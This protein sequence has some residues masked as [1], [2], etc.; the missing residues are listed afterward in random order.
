MAR[1]T[2]IMA[3]IALLA[4][5][6]GYAMFRA[7]E[8]VVVPVAASLP[9]VNGSDWHTD[10][11]VLNPDTTV[12]AA[13]KVVFLPSGNQDD[14]VWFND[15]AH[16]LGYD[17]TFGHVL[18][19]GSATSPAFIPPGQSLILDDVLSNWGDQASG[20]KGALIVYAYQVDA[21]TGALISPVTPTRVVVASRTFTRSTASDGSTQTYGQEVPGIPWPVVFDAATASAPGLDHVT[22]TGIREDA[23]YRTAV[24]LV[25]LSATPV[26][27][28][29]TL[30][31][32]DG[33]QLAAATQTL[34]PYA[35]VQFNSAVRTLF[36]LSPD[37]Q[38]SVVGAT[39]KI[40]LHPGSIQVGP[41]FVAYCSRVDNTTNGP[42]Y[43]EA[44]YDS[45]LPWNC[46]YNATGCPAAQAAT[47]PS[48]LAMFRAATL[49]VVPV[50][51]STAGVN[52]SNWQSDIEIRNV[53]TVPVDVMIV[54]LPTGGANNLAWYQDITNALLPWTNQGSSHVNTSL[55]NIQPGQVVTLENI[56][57]NGGT[58]STSNG[59]GTGDEGALLIWGIQAGSFTSTTPTG[60][61][62]KDIVVTSRT[63]T[64]P[65][66]GT[67]GTYGQEIP[68]LPWYD[69]LDPEKDSHGFN[70]V[71]F[72]GIREDAS[73]RTAVGLV[74]VSDGLT[75]LYPSLNLTNM[76]DANGNLIMDTTVTPA[77]PLGKTAGLLINSLSHSQYN[78]ATQTMFGLA[79]ATYPAIIGATLTATVQSWESTAAQPTPAMVVYCSRVDNHTNDPVYLEQTWGVGLPWAC[80]FDG[81]SCTS[82]TSVGAQRASL[83]PVRPL[84]PPRGKPASPASAARE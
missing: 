28:D 5:N 4:A 62:P 11:E 44:I 21:T 42:D 8:R 81:Q 46:I 31:G 52:N 6:G 14:T 34:Q 58:N 79:S 77:V 76:K 54:F 27:V 33:G 61:T 80:A 47:A 72:T 75:Y 67:T 68:G 23:S 32:A 57:V 1:R 60:G 59:W 50:V 45:E 12:G 38:P 55:A 7:A 19:G 48:T 51:A 22:F 74:N 43:L 18:P 3:A 40:A 64:A 73:Y 39:L 29:L 2:G 70:K 9:G 65:P 16:Q 30:D 17:T 36:G 24:G 53:D 78:D 82:T 69:Y 15:P 10:L 84:D 37:A 71:T 35:H 13:L 66:T 41:A 20:L 63:Y 25:G 26:T 56:L 49:Q 83:A